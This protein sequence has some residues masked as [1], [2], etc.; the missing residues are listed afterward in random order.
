[1]PQGQGALVVKLT[2]RK[3]KTPGSILTMPKSFGRAPESDNFHKQRKKPFSCHSVPL[4]G[5]LWGLLC[6]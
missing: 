3:E 6:H 4:K 5:F 1:M 2:A